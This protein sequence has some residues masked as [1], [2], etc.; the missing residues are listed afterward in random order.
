M[1]LT[2]NK[3]YLTP[4]G[5]RLTI[6]GVDFANV[7]FFCTSANL[8]SL[9][10]PEATGNFQRHAQFFPGDRFAYDPLNIRFLVDEDCKNYL[11]IFNWMQ[12]A[13]TTNEPQ[14]KDVTLSILSSH[15]NVRKQIKFISAFPTSLDGIEF[16]TQASDIEYM[17][18]NCSL[19]Y[20]RFEFIK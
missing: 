20:S 10:L 5:F 9:S 16:N 7:Q 18:V 1:S 12:T 14:F 2:D 4:V 15:N 17:S 3:N 13:V 11:E 19:R 6:D 8:P